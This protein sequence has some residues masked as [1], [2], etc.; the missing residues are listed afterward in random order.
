MKALGAWQ[1]GHFLHALGGNAQ[2]NSVRLF[3]SEKGWKICMFG[4][5]RRSFQEGR[6]RG[7]AGRRRSIFRTMADGSF[8]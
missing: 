4:A 1:F 8:A 5:A 7:R 2:A 3:A 6:M